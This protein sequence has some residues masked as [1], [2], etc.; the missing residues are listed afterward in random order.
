MIIQQESLSTRIAWAL[1]LQPYF[2]AA[3][4]HKALQV[5]TNFQ[6][7]LQILRTGSNDHSAG[8]FIDENSMG[9]DI[10]TVF[11][12]SSRPQGITGVYKFSDST[13]DLKN[14]FE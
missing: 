4:V 5:F 2:P 8:V 9:A 10:A 7:V 12:C 6:T 3:P 13:S 1:T 14:R 11:P